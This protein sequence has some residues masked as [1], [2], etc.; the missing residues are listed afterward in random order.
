ML[1]L[2][3]LIILREFE[4]NYINPENPLQNFKDDTQVFKNHWGIFTR[5]QMGI[6]MNEKYIVDFFLSM[7]KPLGFG[8]NL[9]YSSLN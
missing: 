5:K 2:F 7:P 6:K 1:N 3:V 4:E 9:S 8:N